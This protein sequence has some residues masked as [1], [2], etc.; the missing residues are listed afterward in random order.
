MEFS[1]DL[2]LVILTGIYGIVSSGV[3]S[4]VG[5][6]HEGHPKA[7]LFGQE[8]LFTPPDGSDLQAMGCPRT[9]WKKDTLHD[10]ISSSYTCRKG[11]EGFTPF[12][13]ITTCTHLISLAAEREGLPHPR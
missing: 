3:D 2:H 13:L 11:V 4:S 7:T 9:G 5:F 8:V 1:Q 6:G 12:Y 10:C